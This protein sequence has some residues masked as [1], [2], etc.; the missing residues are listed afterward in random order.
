MQATADSSVVR[1]FSTK[2]TKQNRF[3]TC[4]RSLHLFIM[5]RANTGI[6]LS[7]ASVPAAGRHATPDDSTATHT[8]ILRSREPRHPRTNLP[9]LTSLIP[10]HDCGAREKT[11][12]QT[13][14]LQPCNLITLVFEQ[15]RGQQGCVCPVPLQLHALTSNCLHHRCKV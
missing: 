9:L 6:P 15:R 5:A 13:V 10:P 4:D 1:G 2:P 11:S 12:S 8:K 7:I 3:S 14:T